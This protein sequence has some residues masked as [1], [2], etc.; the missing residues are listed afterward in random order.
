M[1]LNSTR[2][3]GS[4]KGFGLGGGPAGFAVEVLAI[5]GGRGTPGNI[6]AGGGGGFYLFSATASAPKLSAPITIGGGG[7]NGPN[8]IGSDTIV[9]FA[10]SITAPG[11][12][13]PHNQDGTNTFNAGSPSPPSAPSNSGGGGGAG[14]NGTGVGVGGVGKASPS[15]DGTLRAGGGG[16]GGYP[17]RPTGPGTDGGGNGSSALGGSGSPG[18]D[19]TGGGGGGG[20]GNNGPGGSGGSGIVIIKGPALRTFTV[21]PGTNTTSTAPDGSKRATFT[22]SGSITVS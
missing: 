16:G 12:N 13:P 11:G 2:G 4:A 6:S 1:P 7:P 8:N 15:I 14:G 3:A 19:N 5:S 10:V 18:S 17:G 20:G 22:V 21:S 9:G